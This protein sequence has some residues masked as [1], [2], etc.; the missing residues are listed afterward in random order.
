MVFIESVRPAANPDVAV[1]PDLRTSLAYTSPEWL[2][3][4]NAV[5]FTAMTGSAT[6]GE[7]VVRDMRTGRQE[8]LVKG[9]IHGRYAAGGFLVYAADG[10]LRALRFDP[11]RLTTS[12]APV[13]V[14]E[15]VVTKSTGVAD[16]ALTMSGSLV[17]LSGDVGTAGQTLVWVDRN[18][19]EEAVPVPVRNYILLRLSPDGRR[20]ALDVRDQEFDVWL[21]DFDRKQLQ[22]FTFDAGLDEF[23]VWT[24]DGRRIV[25]G[26]G[27]PRSIFWR[28]ADGSGPE[29]LLKK[30]TANLVPSCITPDGKWLVAQSNDAQGM[31]AD[32]VLLSL[33]GDQELKPLIQT[34]FNELNGEVSPDGHW[35]AYQSNESGRDEVLVRPFP[36]VDAGRWQI[37]NGGGTRPAWSRDGRELFFISEPQGRLMS[38]P[39]HLGDRFDAGNPTVIVNNIFFRSAPQ[40]TYDVSPDG[41]RF[42]TLRPVTAQAD[43]KSPPPELN[44]VLNWVEDLKGKVPNK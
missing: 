8:V 27:R 14:V 24:P 42:L 30:S 31:G 9:G 36:N 28:L 6:T 11:K 13:P 37:S 32:I 12:S 25:F 40:R 43:D 20:V 18:G 44:V 41:R 38:A 7:I 26:S 15:H 19:K 39:V 10:A 29:E 5:L 23:P 3:D 4:G 1:K 34:R 21:W 2:P 17:Y 35:I 22:R 16:F 33:G